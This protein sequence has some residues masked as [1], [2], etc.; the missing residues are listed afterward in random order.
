ME[1]KLQNGRY[2]LSTAGIP[3]TV[4]GAEETLQRALLRVCGGSCERLTGCGRTQ[5]GAQ[6]PGEAAPQVCRHDYLWTTEPTACTEPGRQIGT[7]RI[8]GDQVIRETEPLGHSYRCTITEATCQTPETRVYVCSRCGNT[9]TETAP[10]A[11]KNASAINN[12]SHLI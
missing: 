4:S 3:E 12:N 10:F 6:P 7:C 5:A 1:L 11:L 2:S 8:C 9:Y